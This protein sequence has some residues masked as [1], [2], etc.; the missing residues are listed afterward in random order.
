[1]SDY[2]S[3]ESFALN[4]GLSGKYLG[5]S[6]SASASVATAANEHTTMVYFLE[7]MFEVVVEP[8]QSPGAFFSA[9]FTRDRLDQ[10]IAMGR[11]GPDN[12][13]VYVSNVVYG[14]MMAFTFTSTA[15][16]TDVQAALN[17]AYKGI[18]DA[19]FNLDVKYQNILKEGKISVTSLGGTSSATVA[20][21]ASGDWRQYFTENAPLTSAY[22]LSYTF[23]NLG[24][25]SIAKVGET[26]EYAIKECSPQNAAGFML[27]SFEAAAEVNWLATA[28]APVTVDWGS[29]STP[30]SIFYGYLRAKHTNLLNNDFFTYD[31]GY[32]KSPH[33]LGNQSDYYRGELTFWLKP[34]EAMYF[35]GTRTYRHCYWELVWWVPP[36]WDYKCVWLLREIR[37]EEPIGLTD[38]VQAWDEY[39]SADQVVLRGGGALPHEVLT[40]TYNPK[41]PTI[42][43]QWQKRTISLSNDDIAGKSL[44]DA[45]LRGCWLVEDRPATEYEIQYVLSDVTELRMRASYPVLAIRK[46]CLDDPP[47]APPAPCANSVDAPDPIP[48]GY[49]GSYLDEIK[50]TKPMTNF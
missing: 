11:I 3:D 27:D 7:K 6:A 15:S 33:F 43:L 4:T 25:G 38:R 39:T 31:V 2:S 48:L 19:S 17:A 28:P 45:S 36:I 40:L 9:S 23:R 34:Y 5:F 50:V 8:P 22:P 46:I 21:I 1:M 37:D 10:Q 18:F 49:V 30:Q 44:C 13:P 47:P 29:A 42:A 12:L 14:R 41:D 26:T 20:M 16:K 35:Y 24:D 32:L